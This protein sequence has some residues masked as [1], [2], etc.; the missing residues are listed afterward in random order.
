MDNIFFSF[1][2]GEEKREIVKQN[3]TVK[4]RGSGIKRKSQMS[5]NT[6]I[7]NVTCVIPYGIYCSYI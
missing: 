2:S 7:F 1:G 6:H 3:L 4:L 5:E